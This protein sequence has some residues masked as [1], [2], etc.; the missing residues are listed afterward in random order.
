MQLNK[1]IVMFMILQQ[2]IVG[3]Q[4]KNDLSHI[5]TSIVENI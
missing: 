4:V 5:D 2:V 1:F 3:G